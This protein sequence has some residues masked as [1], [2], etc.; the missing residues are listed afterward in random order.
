MR[1]GV[2][3]FVGLLRTP[4]G[5]ARIRHALRH[6]TWPL[7]STLAT[8]H[9]RLVVP[10]TRVVAVIG[11][12]G[13]TTATHAVA[14]AL[15]IDR[16]RSGGNA[17]AAIA[18]G[19]LKVRPGDRHA[20]FEV[21]IAG[22][23]QM[24]PYPRLLRPDVVLVTSIGSEHNASFGTIEA[25]RTEKAKMVRALPASGLAVLNGD[26]LN[27]MWMASQTRA[28]IV[29]FG[30][31]TSHDVRGSEF[32]QAGPEGVRFT[33]EARGERRRVA[34]RL[35]GQPMAY[36]ILGAIAV[37][38]SEGCS[39]D[40]VL[41]RLAAMAPLP[42]RLEPVVLA[43]GAIVIRDDLKSTLESID[44]NVDLLAELP[45]RRRL[46][47]LGDVSEPP[48]SP[49]PV[50]RR[51]GARASATAALTVC[52]GEGHKRYASGAR[53][54]GAPEGTIVDAGRSPLR[55]AEIVRETLGPGDVVLIKGRNNQRLERVALALQGHRVVCDIPVCRAVPQLRCSSCPMLS[56]GWAG[57]R[58]VM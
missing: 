35:L 27:V 38:L 9:R 50:Y 42:G 57:L 1:Y 11:S 5:R 47:V 20:V 24:T 31:G 10:R 51:I 21:G 2:R 33:V 15:A 29:T 28:R 14:A 32:V 48:G 26:D 49:G 40:E 25:T 7:S 12:L 34:I 56:R 22:P 18:F 41:P 36:A 30:F 39:L 46:V 54:F 43:C 4:V 45:A 19:M 16:R 23:G 17:R 53:R 52:V 58:V 44:S 8:L 3:D 37:A 6:R 13:K 55:A